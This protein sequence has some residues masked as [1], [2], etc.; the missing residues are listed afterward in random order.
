MAV[1]KL[2]ADDKPHKVG[3]AF[4][5]RADAAKARDALARDASID[6]SRITLVDPEN[7]QGERAVEPEPRTVRRTLVRSHVILGSVGL[8]L[9]IA[10]AAVLLLIDFRMIASSP[11]LGA[12]VLGFFGAIAGLLVGGFVALRPDH[13]AL[14]D[15]A[16][17]A[18]SE[19]E[20]MVIVHAE[21]NDEKQEAKQVLSA[22]G[23]NVHQ[24]L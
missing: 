8:V 18:A 15:R 17:E 20:W 24:S 14:I 10:L 11:V 1:L 16:R 6:R 23:E 21:S 2:V 19:D 4:A 7:G 13:D 12:V 22:M 9:G 5:D 3:A